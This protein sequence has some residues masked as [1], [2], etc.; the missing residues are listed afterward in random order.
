MPDETLKAKAP[1]RP[2]RLTTE[3]VLQTALAIGLEGLTMSAV[4]RRLG[5]SITVLY[6]YV[7]GR[8]QL[9]RL[10]ASYASERHDY[11]EDDGQHWS[12]YVAQ[13]AV[14]LFTSLT[15]PGQ[16]IGQLVAGGLGPEVEIDRAELWLTTLVNRGFT[17]DE[18]LMMMRQMGEIVI[19]GAVTV[20]HKRTF[21]AGGV[22]F[23]DAAQG[24]IDTRKPD[25]IPHLRTVKT[26][27]AERD[28]VW[29]RTLVQFLKL[30]ALKR[31]ESIDA[32]MLLDF[33]ETALLR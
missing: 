18:A 11:P 5:V 20:L 30:S 15:G 6:G 1:G 31:K 3:Q 21:S 24:L 26:S 33:L 29:P 19:G 9:V 23:R 13:H 12:L 17:A 32:A 10:A 28:H 27:F 4:A 14:A 2:R 16:L 25:H 22:S 7:S 8:E